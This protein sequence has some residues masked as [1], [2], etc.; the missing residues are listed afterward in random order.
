MSHFWVIEPDVNLN[1]IIFCFFTMDSVFVL[2]NVCVCLVDIFMLLSGDI[3]DVN[4][5]THKN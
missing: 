4:V 2:L 1:R 3:Y 5:Y